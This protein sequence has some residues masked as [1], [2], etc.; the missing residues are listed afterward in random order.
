VSLRFSLII[1]FQKGNYSTIP[2]SAKV[3]TD[4][5]KKVE[6]RAVPQATVHPDCLKMPAP[7]RRVGSEWRYTSALVKKTVGFKVIQRHP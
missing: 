7:R 2:D 6:E 4:N 3:T 1:G 5:K